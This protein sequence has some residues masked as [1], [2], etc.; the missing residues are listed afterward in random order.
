MTWA[1]ARAELRRILEATDYPVYLVPPPTIDEDRPVI[2]LT[3]PARDVERRASSVRRT[4]YHQRIMVSG[5]L[6]SEDQPDLDELSTSVDDAVEAVNLAL[7][8]SL[9]LDG[10]A[11]NVTPPS[12]EELAVN[13]YPA[14]SGL[15]YAQ[16]IATLDIE[17]E[18]IG[19]FEP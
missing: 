8:G 4:V 17:I 16:M 15:T 13:E 10:H 6:T 18:R 19:Q 1:Q 12:W 2:F 14:G 9:T 3:P 11:V 5:L 7:D